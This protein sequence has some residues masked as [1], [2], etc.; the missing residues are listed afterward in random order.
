MSLASDYLESIK[1]TVRHK[2]AHVRDDDSHCERELV[3]DGARGLEGQVTHVLT[4]LDDDQREA[5]AD[6]FG[7]DGW[8]ELSMMLGEPAFDVAPWEDLDWSNLADAIEASSDVYYWEDGDVFRRVECDMLDEDGGFLLGQ[9]DLDVEVLRGEDGDVTHLRAL[10][11]FGGP[12]VWLTRDWGYDRLEVHWD[13][14]EA[15]YHPDVTSLLDAYAE[16]FNDWL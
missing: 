14:S 4:L 6:E 7:V 11:T 2:L 5:V 15:W 1:E 10:W 8:A 3:S 13:T 16:T 12:N 9:D